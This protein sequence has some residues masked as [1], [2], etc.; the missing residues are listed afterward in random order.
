[1]A[2]YNILSVVV[3]PC[4]LSERAGYV[5]KPGGVLMWRQ[6][7]NYISWQYGCL[8]QWLHSNDGDYNDH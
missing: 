6:C 7:G 8:L 2:A 5:P 3:L 4:R 1:M